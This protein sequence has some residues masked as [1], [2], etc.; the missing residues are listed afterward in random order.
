MGSFWEEL[1]DAFKTKSERDEERSE[2]LKNALEAEKD[3]VGNLEEL[4]TIRQ[5]E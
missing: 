2:N 3:L 5:A 1:K 4:E